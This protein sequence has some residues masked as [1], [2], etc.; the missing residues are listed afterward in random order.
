MSDREISGIAVSLMF[1]FAAGYAPVRAAASLEMEVTTF[2]DDATV[3]NSQTT[4]S[5]V[6]RSMVMSTLLIN[7]TTLVI[8]AWTSWR[9]CQQQIK[10][11]PRR[12]SE[13][14]VTGAKSQPRQYTKCPVCG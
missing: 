10:P 9:L 3:N 8:A 12:E 13:K 4:D 11:P 1:V 14:A 6:V 5:D 2:I 7:I